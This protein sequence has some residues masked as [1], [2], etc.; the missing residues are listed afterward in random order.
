[1]K[2]LST[3]SDWDQRQVETFLK[4]SRIPIRIAVDDGDY[5]L[6]CSV[7]YQYRDGTLCIVSHKTSK[8]AKLLQARGRCAFEIAPNDP[9]YQGV[10]GKA[11]VSSNQDDVHS[12]LRHLI[13]RYL[14]ATN[15][16]LAKWL[17]SRVDDELG[18]VLTPTWVTSWDYGGRM[19]DAN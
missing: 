14:G 3:K 7:W 10:R 18:F 12:T 15:R 19:D 2:N 16:S 5:P 8:L 13:D 1:M 6:I 9:P 11:E 4:S 17:L